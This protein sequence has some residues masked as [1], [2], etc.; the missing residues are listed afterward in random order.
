[1]LPNSEIG[2]TRKSYNPCPGI[3]SNIPSNNNYNGGFA[4][5]LMVE[6]LLLAFGILFSLIFKISLY[7]FFSGSSKRDSRCYFIN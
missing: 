2:S 6:D 1:M 3:V 5:D 7:R 4:S